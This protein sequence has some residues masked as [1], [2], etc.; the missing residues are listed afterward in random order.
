MCYKSGGPTGVSIVL[1]RRFV[2]IVALSLAAPFARADFTFIHCSDIHIGAGDN[3]VTDAKLFTEMTQLNPKPA[4]VVATGDICEYGTDEQYA[5]YRET[6][7]NLGDVKMYVAPGN[8]DVRWNPRGKEGYTRGTTGP[9]YQSWDYENVHFVTLDSTVLLEHWGHI[10]AEQLHW[11]KGDLEKV[12]PDKP[13]IIGFHHWIGR[14]TVQVDN[15]Q[16]LSDLVKPY[17]VVL[18]LQGHGH[19]DIDWNV[20]GRPATMVAGLYQGSYDIIEV[21]KDELKIAKRFLPKREKKKTDELLRDKSVPEET[22]EPVTQPLMTVPL[23]KPEA[24]RWSAT[25]KFAGKA[26]E[27][28][29]DVPEGATLDYRIDTAKP[30]PLAGGKKVVPTTQ[31][32]PGVHV[33]TVQ[34]TLSDRRAYQ[35]AIPLVVPGPVR[36]TWNVDVGGEIQS[37]LVRDGDLLYVSSMGN[38]LIAINVADGEEKFRVKTKG[39][40]FQSAHIDNGTLYVGSADHFLYAVDAKTGE[41]K[42]TKE[43]GGAILAG[44]NVAQGIVCIGTTDTKI[45][46]V[47]T[48]SGSIIWTVQGKNMFQSR[49]ATDGQRFFVGGWDNHFRCIDAKTGDLKWDLELG[50]KQKYE[51]FSAFAPAIT[52]PAV[53]NGKVFVSTNDGILHALRIEDGKEA[54]HIDWKKMG[55]SSPL[56][57]DGKVYCAMSDEGKVFRADAETGNIDWQGETGSVIYDSSFCVGGKPGPRGAENVFIGNVNGTL[58]AINARTGK[59]EYQYALGPGHLL[60]SPAADTENV[61]IGN[62]TGKLIALPVHST[63][64]A[65]QPTSAR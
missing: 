52:S 54:W 30:E 41:E 10:S 48:A 64:P 3:H 36:P 34:A 63:A 27:V 11:L 31:M 65:T 45:Y 26:I 51:N 47:D 13:V 18:W 4:F 20:N 24:P 35:Q 57:H 15:E 22:I 39:P 2:L 23:K 16:A 12:G 32:T 6:L 37:K 40:I 60:G 53:G 8:H 38:D 59:L 7:K 28:A 49:T 21:T 44:P 9:L 50:R 25:A 62:M 58:N 14:E 33:V 29:A 55:Y 46:G 42:W 5:L 17:N 43:L 56:F 19:S 1:I 61:Y